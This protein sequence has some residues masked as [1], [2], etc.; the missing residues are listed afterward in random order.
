MSS[1]KK[2]KEII[3]SEKIGDFEFGSISVVAVEQDE[4][5]AYAYPDPGGGPY[6]A[7]DGGGNDDVAM[8][9]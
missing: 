3:F 4:I 6:G 9:L 1:E 8:P 5:M 7:V 2:S